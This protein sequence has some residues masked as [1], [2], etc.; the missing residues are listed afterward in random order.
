MLASP[1]SLGCGA[2][3]LAAL[4]SWIPA[5]GRGSGRERAP[6]V[7][8]LARNGVI[9]VGND[10]A[11][12]AIVFQGRRV[13]GRMLP[14]EAGRG[15]SIGPYSGLECESAL[16]FIGPCI[17]TTAA[18]LFGGGGAASRVNG[19]R[20]SFVSAFCSVRVLESGRIPCCRCWPCIITT[21]NFTA[22]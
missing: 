13:D 7:S 14:R 2:C 17:N 16:Y 8:H 10:Q 9:A 11:G 3:R 12:V 19:V 20:N 6:G 15:C 1:A 4:P 18:R 5:A 21:N 22:R